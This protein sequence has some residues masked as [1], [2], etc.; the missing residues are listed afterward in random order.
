MCVNDYTMLYIKYQGLIFIF[1]L[2]I[3]MCGY[4]RVINCG[5]Y[6]KSMWK[7]KV[8]LSNYVEL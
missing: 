4:F 8:Y 5:L 6:V 7:N 2:I 1:S 3:P